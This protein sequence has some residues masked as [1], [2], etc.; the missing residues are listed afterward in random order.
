[1]E[2]QAGMAP[3]TPDS[4]SGDP[5]AGAG[6]IIASTAMAAGLCFVLGLVLGAAWVDMIQ[7][8]YEPVFDDPDCWGCYRAISAET[9]SLHSGCILIAVIPGVLMG[10]SPFPRRRLGL[11]GLIG[12]IAA[13]ALVGFALSTGI[14][15]RLG[16]P[17]DDVLFGI[18]A[19]LVTVSIGA[20][21]GYELGSV[22][23]RHGQQPYPP[24]RELVVLM[25]LGLVV[26]LVA[27]FV[28]LALV[29]AILFGPA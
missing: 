28:L 22:I 23:R 6:R 2:R 24:I 9:I 5:R 17:A 26:L 8:F 11:A 14:G 16:F 21:F 19:A 29:D 18:V 12:A 3:R 4:A 13:A 7:Q 1:M 10:H 25:V 20:G 27:V 15:G